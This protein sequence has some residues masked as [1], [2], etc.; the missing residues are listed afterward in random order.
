M[1]ERIGAIVQD[2]NSLGLLRGLQAR[3]NCQAEIVEGPRAIGKS[4][5]MKS[6]QGRIAWAEFQKKTVDLIVRFTDADK[7]RWQDVRRH[8][9]ESVFPKDARSILVCGV[10]RHHAQVD[11]LARLLAA[12][13][14]QAGVH[15]HSV[16]A[17]VERRRRRGEQLY[18]DAGETALGHGPA[19]RVVRPECLEEE[20]PRAR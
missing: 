1:I 5:T 9:L 15:G 12:L 18:L 19:G 20:R 16:E 7:G 8:E 10:A 11:V 2:A 13:T 3:L 14:E 6:K 4:S 17:V